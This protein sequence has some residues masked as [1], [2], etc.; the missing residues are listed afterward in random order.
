MSGQWALYWLV[1]SVYT[2]FRG[3][4]IVKLNGR[5]ALT[6]FGLVNSDDDGNESGGAATAKPQNPSRATMHVSMQPIFHQKAT[7]KTGWWVQVLYGS[8]HP[9]FL[10]GCFAHICLTPQVASYSFMLHGSSAYVS[11]APFSECPVTSTSTCISSA[12]FG[13]VFD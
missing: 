7:L 11:A 3:L 5:V 10:S 8:L 1:E 6:F 13:D 12:V 2:Y 4:D 9:L